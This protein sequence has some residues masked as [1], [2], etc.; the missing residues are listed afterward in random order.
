MKAKKIL[1]R[2][3]LAAT[4]SF[5]LAASAGPALAQGQDQ[6][7][8]VDDAADANTE[9]A[10]ILE[11]VVVTASISQSIMNSINT[12]RYADNIVDVVDA[13]ALGVLP[14]QSIADA[15]G[16]V[17][18]VTTVRGS[19][20]SSQLNIR[21]MNGDFI[22]TT[23][24]GR[25]EASTSGYTESTRWMSFDQYPAEMITQAAVYKSP[26]A[27]QIEGGVAGI[28][29]LKTVDPLKAP[30][31]H[32]IVATARY[33]YNDG[34][35]SIG[36]DE[37]GYRYSFSYQGKFLEDTLGF[38]VGFSSLEQPNSFVG[39]RAGADGQIGY[40]QSTDWN[41]DGSND[42]RAR[43]FQ[44]QAGTG[45]DKRDGLLATLVWAPTDSLKAQFD[46][47][48]SD[49]ERGDERHGI[50]V[51]GLQ[52]AST[53][54]LTNA[55]VANGVVTGATASLTNPATSWDSSP[56]FESRTEDQSTSA[57][58]ESI[59]LNL[60]WFPNENSSLILD[61]STSEGTKTRK[62]RIAS[63]HAY[64][65]TVDDAGNLTDWV[66]AAGQSLTYNY[67]GRNI[68]TASFSG[69]DFTDLSKMRLSRYEEYPHEY[70]DEVD[71]YKLDYKLDFDWTVVSG[72]EAGFRSSERVFNSERGTFLYGSRD[73]QFNG[74]CADNLTTGDAAIDCMPQSL[75]GFVSVQSVSGA[76]DHFV[77]NDLEGLAT[78]IFGAGNFEGLK[79]FSRDWTFVESG[80]LKEEV[81]AAY[82][83]ANLEFELGS[84]P[85]F[86]NFGVR[87]VKT[88]VKSSGVQNVG[89][90]NGVPI[91]DDV[92][93]TQDNYDYVKYGPD[94]TDTLPSLN[95]NFE[96]SEDNIL[97]FA[98]AK[99]MGRPPV[100]QLK[101]GAGS[102]NSTNADGE[103]E[104]NVWTKGSPYL[105]PFRATQFDLSI[106]HYFDDGGAVTAA[107]F[108]KD[109]E[110]LVEKVFNP[111][112]TVDFDELGIEVP[113]GQVPGA[114]ETFLNNDNGGYIR[115][116]E[117]AVTKT[118]SNLP[119]AWSGLGATASYSYTQSE[120]EV[121]GGNLYG[122]NLPLPGLS[123]NVWSA[124]L[125]YDYGSFATHVNVRYR[126]EYI[127]NLPIPGSSTPVYAQ[128]YTT[129]DA[130][131]SYQFNNGIGLIASANNL[132]DE[133]DV[134][135][136]GVDDTFGEFKQFGRQFYLGINYTY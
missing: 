61:I 67:N 131:V 27:S 85:V 113:E 127:L 116:I 93:M 37:S 38:A 108:Y 69:V 112:G 44:W 47:F 119:G 96:L 120:T 80:E 133:A 50:T 53:F 63:M 99:V 24:N 6:D 117:L 51:G 102:W 75:D 17:P 101:G 115:G 104:Y 41:G 35:D 129:V 42:A 15:L 4:I 57:D 68:P 123:E 3:E 65:L 19:G 9:P 25:E 79:V 100:G 92:G 36:A 34:A 14:D 88:D 83:M 84:V 110:S 55:T 121:A 94:Y 26:M 109:I 71:A 105:D 46:Y 86:G 74:Y 5:L 31:K 125:F 64:D 22:Q 126:D 13:G 30:N 81:D 2:K 8:Q 134:I 54:D 11:E 114:F 124:T 29:D 45:T 70:T 72:I 32:N 136:Y 73:G 98:A 40:D 103:I 28:V 23:L 33:S 77:V 76:P 111:A 20:Q 82:L 12:K 52:N 49:F 62:D 10:G 7:T 132:T 91:T 16:R 90:G 128:P 89:A 1:R 48:K 78:S 66:E 130:Q 43:A 97:R 21:G 58:T 87:Y 107:V 18:G 59:G 56:W 106:E 118:F 122:E 135:E 39:S 95:L 60:A